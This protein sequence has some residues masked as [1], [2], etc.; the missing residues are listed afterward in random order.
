LGAILFYAA[1]YLIDIQAGLNTNLL[2][3]IAILGITIFSGFYW[4]P[5]HIDFAAF[6]TKGR[7]GRQVAKFQ[8]ALR[9]VAVISPALAGYLIVQYSYSVMFL[10]GM[11]VM[12][13]SLFPIF[14]LP[15]TQVEY[16]FGFFETF[17]KM[18]SRRFRNMSFSMISHG[19]ENVVGIVVWPL[20]LFTIFN[21]EHLNVGLFAAVIVVIG[22]ALQYVLG[23]RIDK[24]PIKKLFKYGTRVYAIGWFFKALVTTVIGVFAA[25]LFHT[26]GSILM[27]TP[28]EALYYEK[29]ADSGHYI[30][31][32]TV[33]R[34]TAIAIGRLGMMLLL[35][36]IITQFEL[37]I[38]FV[39]AAIVSLG[40]T[41]LTRATIEDA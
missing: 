15:K 41:L 16:E 39:F 25:S 28:F 13:F 11:I 4:T 6:S 8:I 24:G 34:E 20:F 14:Y 33:I 23:K 27:G 17:K 30:D 31:E 1:V 2:L 19:A 9:I 40:I 3:A 35:L 5:F 18:F 37:S 29:A 7:R 22:A 26:L 32:F 10:I 21:G 36:L 12:A 38:A